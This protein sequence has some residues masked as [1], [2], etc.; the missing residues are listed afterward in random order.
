M[1]RC[2]ALTLSHGGCCVLF[3]YVY[4]R[5][6]IK[7]LVHMASRAGQVGVGAGVGLGWVWV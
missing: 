4:I 3:L 5:E 1:S 6:K 2:I 7:R